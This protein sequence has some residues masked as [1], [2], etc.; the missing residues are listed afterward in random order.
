MTIS[1]ESTAQQ[2]A[3]NGGQPACTTP[4]PARKLFG[5]EE[6]QAV[7]DLFDRAIEEG[8][9][10][11]GYNGEQEEAYC[12]AFAAAQGGGFADGV[13]SGTTAVYVALRAL[14]LEPG[15]EVIVPPISD[16]G[17]IMPVT[18]MGCI[19]VPADTAPGE[20]NVSVEQIK[21]RI[22]DRTR[23]IVIAHISGMPVDMDP[24]LELAKAHNLPIVEDCAQSHGAKYK[25]KCVGTLGD[26]AA[27][28]TMFGKHHATGGQGGVVFTTNEDLYWKARRYADRGKPMNLPGE[29]GNVAASLNLNMDE[30]HAAI[31]T[32]QIGKLPGMIAKRRAYMQALDQA[33]KTHLQSVR[34]VTEREGD[35]ACYWFPFF[36]LDLGKLT[37]DK[38]TFVEAVNAEGVSVS[39]S[40]LIVP[41]RMKWYRQTVLYNPDRTSQQLSQYDLPNAEAT[42]RYTFRG[43]LHEGFT[44]QDVDS[45]IAA[46]TKVEAAYLKD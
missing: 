32:V 22:T 40:Y 2:L 6:K 16:P 8:S 18:M 46:F 43:L 27:F 5:Q 13:N 42:D 34:V 35:E 30:L 11:L 1:S 17:G 23:A 9:H 25:G 28:S 19:P 45:H 37:V 7:M 15:S 4:A 41:T 36:Q 12:K 31:G 39:S 33:C 10:I 38:D 26:I 20:F 24:I 44:Q 21:A 29:T 3:I 14:E